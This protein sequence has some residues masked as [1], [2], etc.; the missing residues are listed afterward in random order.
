MKI[1]AVDIGN[2]NIKRAVVDD[3]IVVSITRDPTANVE[4]VAAQIAESDLH[5]ALSSVRASAAQVIKL[6]LEKS[7]SAQ[8]LLEIDASIAEPVR[9]FY[10]GMGA[11][12]IADAASARVLKP[13]QPVAVIGF[14]TG[15]AITAITTDGDFAGG[16][17]TLGLGPI[18]KVLT[19]AIP[20]L[21]AIDPRHVTDLNPGFDIYNALC[22]GTLAAH[23]GA[24]E[25]WVSILREQLGP[26]L[27]VV[28]T[29]G[30]SETVAPLTPV[31]D[32]C[33]PLLTIK[34]IWEIARA[35]RAL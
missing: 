33:D 16:F 15:T 34:G 22:R 12:R 32:H 14:G 4:L 17:T 20:A 3:G 35:K 11:D 30:W 2:T 1:L 28:A 31:I 5:V 21:P 18:C 24:I 6:A 23:V 29:G 10:T 7:K 27:Y 8:L 25:K 13:G 9:G 26:S 19:D